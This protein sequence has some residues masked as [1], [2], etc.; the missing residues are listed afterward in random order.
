MYTIKHGENR[1]Y[2]VND[3]NKEIGEITYFLRDTSHF[4]VNHTYVDPKYRGQNI[5]RQ[6]VDA[7]VEYARSQK[8]KIIPDC[9]Y[10]AT[11]FNKNKELYRDVWN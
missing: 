4:V 3:E 9:Y 7:M 5:A 6:L 11:V 1:F 10:V 8:R 2:V